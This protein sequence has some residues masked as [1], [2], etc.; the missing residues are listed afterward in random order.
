M[1]INATRK[2]SKENI[3]EF[4]GSVGTVARFLSYRDRFR[5]PG[6]GIYQHGMDHQPG[7]GK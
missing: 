5:G 7:G 4:F 2:S 6:R 3:S 1:K